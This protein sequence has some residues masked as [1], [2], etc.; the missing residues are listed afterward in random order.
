MNKM[1][2]DTAREA[3]TADKPILGELVIEHVDY[4]YRQR[5]HKFALK[6]T[7]YQC[8]GSETIFFGCGFETQFPPSFGSGLGSESSLTSKKLRTQ[9]R[10]RPLIFSL[11]QCQQ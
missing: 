7:Y 2:L 11:S 10:I 9:F 6:N 5:Q 8:C 4:R 1:P 3:S